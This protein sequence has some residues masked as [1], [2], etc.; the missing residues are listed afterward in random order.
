M[1]IPRNTRTLFQISRE[2]FVPGTGFE[3]RISRSLAYSPTI[4]SPGS[5][6]GIS[7]NVSLENQC[8]SRR[9]FDLKLKNNVLEISYSE[10]L[11]QID[12]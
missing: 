12:I 9:Q 7:L 10:I 1:L 8:Y 2:K 3:P 5:I 6:D 4:N 11:N